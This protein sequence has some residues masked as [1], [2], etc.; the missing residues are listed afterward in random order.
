MNTRG[1]SK[2]ALQL[3]L[4]YGANINIKN[5]KGKSYYKKEDE[6]IISYNTLL[7]KKDEEPDIFDNVQISHNMSPFIKWLYSRK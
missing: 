1:C 3:L 7:F 2:E 5:N 4:D 6:P